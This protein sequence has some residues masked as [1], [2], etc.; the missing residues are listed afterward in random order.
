MYFIRFL[1]IIEEELYNQA[2]I[3]NDDSRVK[4]KEEADFVGSQFVTREFIDNYC[5]TYI[6]PEDE[7]TI[8]AIKEGLEAYIDDYNPKTIAEILNDN[9]KA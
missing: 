3:D 9:A 8:K 4:C 6:N 7:T 2:V 5:K 1:E